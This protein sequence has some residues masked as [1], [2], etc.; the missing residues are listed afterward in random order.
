MTQR[1]SQKF[2]W[3]NLHCY[4]AL[5]V[6]DCDLCKTLKMGARKTKEELEPLSVGYAN[7]RVYVDFAGPVATTANGHKFIFVVVDAFSGYVSATP[8][9]DT[10][11]VSAMNALLCDWVAQF[12]LPAWIHSDRGTA[13][14]SEL[15]SLLCSQFGI[16]QTRSTAYHPQGNGRAEAAVKSLKQALKLH[17]EA[18]GF[19]VGPRFLFVCSLYVVASTAAQAIRQHLSFLV[20]KCAPWVMW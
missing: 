10:S 12:G 14:E 20:E 17:F 9:R 7:Q 5:F 4:V 18:F 3:F 13:F 8:T 2:Y 16:R 6:F 15:A 11:A 1:I 19:A